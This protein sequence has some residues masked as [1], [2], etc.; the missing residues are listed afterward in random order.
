MSPKEL[1]RAA[2]IKVV[3]RVLKWLSDSSNLSKAEIDRLKDDFE[4]LESKAGKNKNPPTKAISELTLKEVE[5]LFKIRQVKPRD[6]PEDHW[7][8]IPFQFTTST[9]QAF[10]ELLGILS[11]SFNL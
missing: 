5:S 8:L 11:E 7:E 4:E 6:P 2:A 3:E 1:T 9:E 10:M